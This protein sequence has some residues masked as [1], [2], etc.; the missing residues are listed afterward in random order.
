MKL[1]TPNPVIAG[2]WLLIVLFDLFLLGTL[3][4]HHEDTDQKAREQV[5]YMNRL[6]ADQATASFDRANALI[7]DISD[8]LLPD[9]FESV[10]N[11]SE[12]RRRSIEQRLRTHQ[13]RFPNVVSISITD[14]KGYVF[15]NSVGTPP[16]VSLGDR[17]YFLKLKEGPRDTPVIS[18]AIK[19]R[20]SNRW[21][22]QVTRRIE[23]PDGR[24]AGMIVA[25]L[26]MKEAFERFY[27]SIA[28]QKDMF[29]TLRNVQNQ[30][31]VRYPV[32]EDKQG[33]VISGSAG[34]QTLLEGFQEKV[35]IST[36]P[37][38][39]IERFVA[40]RKLDDYPVYASVGLSKDVIFQTWKEEVIVTLLI[41]LTMAVAGWF[42]TR[43][44][45]RREMLMKELEASHQAISDTLIM[46]EKRAS[47][48][49][50]TGLRNRRSFNQKLLETVQRARR[51][52]SRFSILMM[53]ID[54]FKSINDTYGHQMGDLVLKGFCERISERIRESDY[55]A[56]WGGEEFILLLDSAD[57]NQ[58]AQLAETLRATIA[59]VRID[60]VPS[61]TVSIGVAEYIADEAIDTLLARADKHLYAAKAAGRNRVYPANESSPDN[62]N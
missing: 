29:I 26:G 59:S 39:R 10:E 62:S 4:S 54:H 48:D 32:V 36:S 5:L 42:A 45:L 51:Y 22:V 43:A 19:G 53:D 37:I 30:I 7:L 55:L 58:A 2:L 15:A 38:D 46:A 1:N 34:T 57:K 40:L 33:T 16:G 41:M 44:I 31:F 20:V 11:M 13:K 28:H 56:R 18:D 3:Y 47:R 17:P 24:F 25:N 14:A 50:L 8:H 49:E 12:A 35:I 52:G 27:E 60:P 6:I 61:L 23:F 9:D 21:G